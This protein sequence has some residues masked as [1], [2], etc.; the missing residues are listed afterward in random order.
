[1]WIFIQSCLVWC[2]SDS[3]S[4]EHS[5]QLKIFGMLVTWQIRVKRNQ[6]RFNR[7]NFWLHFFG[8][9]IFF[10]T[11]SVSNVGSPLSAHKLSICQTASI[12]QIQNFVSQVG[13]A[14]CNKSIHLT[15]LNYSDEKSKFH[16]V[17]LLETD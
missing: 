17:L 12:Q 7:I 16:T 13:I 2:L 8:L 14:A 6:L 4:L 10:P 11:P 1:L 9:Q 5:A 15:W 3:T